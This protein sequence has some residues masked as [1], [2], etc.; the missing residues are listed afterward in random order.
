M[1]RLYS[2]FK[3]WILTCVTGVKVLDSCLLFQGE[4]KKALNIY[5]RTPLALKTKCLQLLPITQQREVD[6]SGRYFHVTSFLII[7]LGS[8][9]TNNTLVDATVESSLHKIGFI[10]DIECVV[11][12]TEIW[13]FQM[14]FLNIRVT[15]EQHKWVY[16]Y[17]HCCKLDD[18]QPVDICVPCTFARQMCYLLKDT[19]TQHACSRK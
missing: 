5:W 8:R 17:D 10:S 6:S 4:E 16:Y 11:E 7:T 3:G 19:A 12:R 15:L 14:F 9:R 1:C 2:S 13:N 18:A